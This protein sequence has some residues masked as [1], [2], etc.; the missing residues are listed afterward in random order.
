VS[1]VS[2][3]VKQLKVGTVGGVLRAGDELMHISPTE[4]ELLMEVRIS[5][6]DI[7]QLQTGMR[8]KVRVDA[9][10]HSTQGALAGTLSYL[11]SD[12]LA[13]PGPGGQPV[14]YYRGHIRLDRIILD[15]AK[16][17]PG[18]TATVDILT[19]R[20]SVLHYLAKPLYRAFGGAM[21]ER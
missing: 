7:A 9:L 10:D 2:G 19:R 8:A 11:S 14:Q 6:T 12:T 4:G 1:P 16:L 20:R 17:K 5:P 3:I 21:N 18:M 15:S 13:E